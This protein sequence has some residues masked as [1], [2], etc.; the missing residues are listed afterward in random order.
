MAR[1]YPFITFHI[2]LVGIWFSLRLFLF[3]T[4]SVRSDIFKLF[5][6]YFIL[7]LLSFTCIAISDAY[8]IYDEVGMNFY[9]FVSASIFRSLS[10]LALTLLSFGINKLN[11]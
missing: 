6:L 2:S 4:K 3:F 7:I 9:R 5:R 11:D 8:L 1:V 10:V